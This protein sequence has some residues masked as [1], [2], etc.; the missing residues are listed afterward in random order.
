MAKEIGFNYD[1]SLY[2]SVEELFLL[3]INTFIEL[4]QLCILILSGGVHL[5]MFLCKSVGIIARYDDGI[6]GCWVAVIRILIGGEQNDGS[7][8]N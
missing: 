4:D 8:I 1:W 3:P 2:C 5:S 7:Y 6:C